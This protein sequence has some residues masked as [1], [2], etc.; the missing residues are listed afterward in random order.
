[1]ILI[2]L[3]KKIFKFQPKNQNNSVP[4]RNI[5]QV[6]QQGKRF[7]PIRTLNYVDEEN[8]NKI[9]HFNQVEKKNFKNE[10][11]S[12]RVSNQ[13]HENE[14]VQKHTLNYIKNQTECEELD[15]INTLLKLKAQSSSSSSIN[16]SN[17]ELFNNLPL[18]SPRKE[19]NTINDDS[20]SYIKEILDICDTK[21]M[22][23]I[24]NNSDALQN[25]Q[26]RKKNS[27]M[28]KKLQRN[29]LIEITN[30][31]KMMADS[32]TSVDP[33]LR[34]RH[35]EELAK[36][37]KIRKDNE[38]KEIGDGTF[39][40]IINQKSKII[41]EKLASRKM[42]KM[43]QSNNE[44]RKNKSLKENV[45]PNNIA[46][47]Q[48]LDENVENNQKKNTSEELINYTLK[49]YHDWI[50]EKYK[51]YNNIQTQNQFLEYSKFNENTDK[52][53]SIDSKT[54]LSSIN[55]NENDFSH[56][57]QT[58]Q[59][60]KEGSINTSSKI[61]CTSL[62]K[63]NNKRIDLKA[64]KEEVRQKAIIANQNKE[65]INVNHKPTPESVSNIQI[66]FDLT[67]CQLKSLM[68]PTNQDAL[69]N[70]SFSNSKL[71]QPKVDHL[72]NCFH[73]FDQV[74]QKKTNELFQNQQNKLPSNS[75]N[76]K[77]NDD[78]NQ[79][80]IPLKKENYD[81]YVI[82]HPVP[83]HELVRE[84]NMSDKEETN[85]DFMNNNIKLD[86]NNVFNDCMEKLFSSNNNYYSNILGMQMINSQ[87]NNKNESCSQ[88][89]NQFIQENEK[90]N[91]E[92]I[93]KAEIDLFDQDNSEDSV[94]RENEVNK[95]TSCLEKHNITVNPLSQSQDND[96]MKN[97][98]SEIE[99]I[100]G[101]DLE[102]N[103]EEL[104]NPQYLFKHSN[105]FAIMTETKRVHKNNN[106]KSVSSLEHTIKN[107][108]GAI[109]SPKINS[110]KL[111]TSLSKPI[112]R[113]TCSSSINSKYKFKPKKKI[114]TSQSQQPSCTKKE[115]ISN[116]SHLQESN[117][118]MPNAFEER[119]FKRLI[120][121]EKS[122]IELLLQTTE[123]IV[124]HILSNNNT[125]NQLIH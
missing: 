44:L 30:R 116:S 8:L 102:Y 17:Y 120:Q 82:N 1:M 32:L 9:H 70:N 10:S 14:I 114:E 2:A 62:L 25:S 35:L 95:E 78:K 67:Q 19:Q 96:L 57:I 109:N 48:H 34:R 93:I 24:E 55:T 77:I 125:C 92:I 52:I 3:M 11:S 122:N 115:I 59:S 101:I 51:Q 107:N 12:V 13:N 65:E 27:Q 43:N 69:I 104:M 79:T 68:S 75:S 6:P 42:E 113:K 106:I 18:D 119:Y 16:N 40:P 108:N 21:A 121:Q 74:T 31:R 49:D 123:N 56:L 22:N 80:N 64:I 71:P 103:I 58:N 36:V 85:L 118:D 89:S 38:K 54:L 110:K 73:K 91:K 111:Q 105:N 45:Q 61:N 88:Q 81:E 117:G 97:N 37:E 99:S 23:N 84:S 98:K 94:Q 50:E 53:R 86:N 60:E 112:S 29:E 47:Y 28:F 15:F 46:L 63:S 39:I 33:Y 76:R 5:L 26:N 100:E 87:N 83:L 4:K 41:C 72:K 20:K 66:Q 124:T 90:N 7:S